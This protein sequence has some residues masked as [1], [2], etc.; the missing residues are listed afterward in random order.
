MPASS[1]QTA[2]A[3]EKRPS[4]RPHFSQS[5]TPT[6]FTDDV[7]DALVDDLDLRTQFARYD[8]NNNGYLDADE[9]KRV[10]KQWET[11]GVPRSDHEVEQLFARLDTVDNKLTYDQF[12]IVMLQ[13]A[14]W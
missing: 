12:C 11:F 7:S 10:F 6:R 8:T 9:F 4:L 5:K 13:L 14:K 2:K 1:Q 3:G